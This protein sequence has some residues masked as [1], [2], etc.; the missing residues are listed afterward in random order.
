[1]TTFT[2]QKTA[3][4]HIEGALHDNSAVRIAI[5]VGRFNG[6]LVESLVEGAIDALV[7]HGVQGENIDVVRVPGAFE[8]PLTA[9]RLAESDKYDAVVV[10]GAI[11]RGATPHFD[12]VANESAK[13]LSQVALSSGKPVINGILTTENIEQTIERAGTKAGNKGYEAALTALEMVSVLKAI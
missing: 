10:L 8:L 3:I 7:R 9:K 6:F 1:M 11:I 4:T 13:G 2:A 5:A 12:I